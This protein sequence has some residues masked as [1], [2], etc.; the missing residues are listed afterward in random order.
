MKKNLTYE[1]IILI[2]ISVIL[3]IFYLL[4]KRLNYKKPFIV[5]YNKRKK[6][7]LNCLEGKSIFWNKIENLPLSSIFSILSRY[8]KKLHLECKNFPF[9]LWPEQYMTIPTSKSE[10]SS[11]GEKCCRET[12]RW[13]F[14]N[15]VFLKVRPSCLRNPKTNRCLELDVYSDQLKLAIEYNGIQHYQWPNFCIVTLDDFNEQRYRD[16]LKIDLCLKNNIKLICVTYQIPPY[17]IPIYIYI[18]LIELFSRS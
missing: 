15:F 14:P 13:L 2:Y 16:F 7:F 1:N 10:C 18:R 12:M 8:G 17:M 4:R 6:T 9:P 5:Y 3:I 11:L